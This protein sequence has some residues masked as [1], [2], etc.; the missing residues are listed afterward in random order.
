[1][2]DLCRLVIAAGGREGG[3]QHKRPAHKLRD[4][5]PVWPHHL[6]EILLEV[7]RASAQGVNRLPSRSG[8]RCGINRRLLRRPH[9]RTLL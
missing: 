9:N 7:R 3:D 6:D 8:A 2:G 1:M 4:P 5:L